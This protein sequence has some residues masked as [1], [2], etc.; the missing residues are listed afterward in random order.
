M[1]ELL[2]DYL[3][4][5]R[6]E[7]QKSAATLRAY[8]GDL[9]DFVAWLTTAGRSLALTT[10]FELR[11]YLIELE[12]QGL[13]ATSVQRK[14]ASLRGLFT[15]L[16]ETGRIDKNPARLIKGPK[17]PRRVPRFL[18]AAEVETL[19]L[20]PFDAS[21]QGR[22]DRAILEVLY[23]TGCRVSE[24]AGMQLADLDLDEG[25]V[26]VLGKG[27]K[28][29]LALL[30]GPACQALRA[31]LPQRSTILRETGKRDPGAVWLNQNGGPLSARWVFETV[32]QRAHRAGLQQT[33]TPHGLRHSFATHLL[34]RGADLRT[35][36][37]LLG[38][39]RLVTTEIY[40]H[41]S[42]GRLRDVY[43]HAHP[44]G[45]DRQADGAT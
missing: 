35:V 40:T 34:D 14:L 24:C 41:V 11:R 42:I 3:Q 13:T 37:E 18:T 32:V 21:T 29:R 43:D 28:Q 31:W 17:A 22:R 25:I 2:P 16:H 23:S 8:Q 20:Q 15:W 44:H 33:L 30:G 12:Q 9:R 10:R 27:K 6:D 45:R 39:A 36:Q 19:L 5:L 7:R 4:F 38:H 1:A 26:R